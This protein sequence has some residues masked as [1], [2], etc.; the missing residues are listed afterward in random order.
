MLHVLRKAPNK[1]YQQKRTAINVMAVSKVLALAAT[2]LGGTYI[3]YENWRRSADR[4]RRR[5]Q[6]RLWNPL[7]IDVPRSSYLK[8]SRNLEV[9]FLK[10]Y[11]SGAPACPVF[12]VGPRGTGKSPIMKQVVSGQK[13]VLYLDLHK[14]PVSSGEEFF[15]WLVE[16]SG[17]STPKTNEL[18]RFLLREPPRK[19]RL[20]HEEL[21]EALSVFNSVL[22]REKDLNWPN[23]VPLICVDDIQKLVLCSGSAADVQHGLKALEQTD[24]YVA[25]FID[26]CTHLIESKLAH[27]VFITTAS[28]LLELEVIASFRHKR[29]L[30]WIN[31]PTPE[32]IK[33]FLKEHFELMV[34]KINPN[35]NQTVA[36]TPSI[37]KPTDEQIDW[38]VRCIGGHMDDLDQ[39]TSALLRGETFHILLRRMIAESINFVEGILES[40]LKSASITTNPL[41]RIKILEKY[42]RLWRLMENLRDHPYVNR[43]DLINVIFKDNVAELD[44]YVEY[45]LVSYLSRGISSRQD[46]DIHEGVID[47]YNNE[48]GSNEDKVFHLVDF[49]NKQ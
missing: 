39:V 18:V 29:A 16:T 14:N 32:G 17:Y 28:H 7:A 31:H 40:I 44:Q 45:D 20:T 3:S 48:D 26:W 36:S 10:K 4:Q 12:V 43:R 8:I 30:V 33:G 34:P 2:V 42:S 47:V 25:K 24:P 5:I 49:Q 38:I 27:V 15:F 21:E 6:N 1:V 46:H 37:S 11:F 23:G 35:T 41:D 22:Q 13:M 19:S 9:N